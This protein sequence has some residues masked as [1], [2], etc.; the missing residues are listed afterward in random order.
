MNKQDKKHIL[1]ADD[2]S[3]IRRLFGSKLASAGFEVLY[4]TDGN[5][6]I[7]M[8]RRF[9]P[10]LIVTDIDMPNKDG[11]EATYILKSDPQT[12]DIY[13][14]FL[15]N[16]DL[17]IEGEKVIK[18]LEGAEYIQKGIDLSEFIEKIKKLL[19]YKD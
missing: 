19:I 4:A 15:T 10:D 12:K 16:A 2:D 11:I 7:E 18:E 6:V 14:I 17:S 1:L 9:L 13:V 8:A 3:T 5:E